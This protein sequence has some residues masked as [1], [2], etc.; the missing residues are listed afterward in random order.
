MSQLALRSNVNIGSVRSNRYVV[1]CHHSIFGPLR[2]LFALH[3]IAILEHLSSLNSSVGCNN[4][5]GLFYFVFFVTKL[6]SFVPGLRFCIVLGTSFRL[7][8][9]FNYHHESFRISVSTLLYRQV[10]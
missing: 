10:F 8:S 7:S 3:S 2:S 9:R 1:T 6:F 4:N 5:R